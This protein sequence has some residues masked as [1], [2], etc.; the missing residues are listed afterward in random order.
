MAS[1]G[2]SFQKTFLGAAGTSASSTTLNVEDVFATSL[3]TGKGSGIYINNGIRLGARGGGSSVRFDGVDDRLSRAS[4]LTNAAD[5]KTFTLSAFVYPDRKAGNNFF[6]IA[7][8]G[9][10]GRFN[11][12]VDDTG[13]L[14]VNALG[15]DAGQVLTLESR[16][17]PSSGLPGGVVIGNWQHILISVD[18]SDTSK[19]HLYIDDVIPGHVDFDRYNDAVIDFT[20]PKV[21]IA[22]SPTAVAGAQRLSNFYLDFTYRDLSTES[23]RRLF[24]NANLEPVAPP[25]NS[26]IHMKLDGTDANT[27]VNSGTGGNFTVNGSPTVL[28]T[29]G[30]FQNSD[31]AAGGLVW[32][33]NRTASASNILVD[34]ERGAKKFLASDSTAA[35][36][37]GNASTSN[38]SVMDFTA[39]G[40]RI[41]NYSNVNV[42][43]AAFC[44]WTF[45]KQAK[46]FDVVTYSGQ[47][48]D[49]A[50]SHNLGVA[51][52]MVII[53]RTDDS[54]H[55]WYVYHRSLNLSDN[56]VLNADGD[57][58]GNNFW[59]SSAP[60][61]T[62][63]NI[64]GN[65]A[66]IN[67]SGGS[68]VAY[69][70]AH[71]A[72]DAT[73]TDFGSD[74]GPVI[75]CGS[76]TGNTSGT[77]VDLGFEPQFVMI[78]KSTASESWYVYDNMRGVATGGANS[79]DKKLRWNTSG[80]EAAVA[81]PIIAFSS[82]GFI[83]ESTDNEINGSGTYVYMAIR[84]LMGAPTK[85]LTGVPISPFSAVT[86]GTPDD[87]VITAF[88]F[89][90]EY[91]DMVMFAKRGGDSENFQIADRV[92]GFQSTSTN[93]DDGYT[94]STLETN[95]TNA[96]DTSSTA[97]HQTTTQ[98]DYPIGP[99]LRSVSSGGNFL[100]YR[101]RRMKGY[102]DMVTWTGT[103]S[104]RTQ[105]H[106]LGAVPEMIWV[107]PRNLAENWAVY[108]KDIGATKYLQLNT[109]AAA[110]TS[111]TR[112]NDTTPT[113][114]VF[115]LGAD[116]EVNASS[117]GPYTY[118]A[119]LFSTLDGVSKV[120]SYTGNDG[121]T[122]VDCGFSNGARFILIK[123]TNGS[124]DWFIFD[125]TRG[126][127][128]GN[129]PSLKLNTTEAED[130]LGARDIIDPLSAGFTVNAN[131]GGVNDNG[132]TFI[133]YAIA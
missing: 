67:Q 81:S 94:T 108:H 2:S 40:F 45:R 82:K 110:A 51:P 133:F 127:V 4:E 32:V 21:G 6:E 107:H 16:L 57:T 11:F 76:Y 36:V 98:V 38:Q 66:A 42:N 52:G 120:G 130:D 50:L 14:N 87:N 34:T 114:S 78:K 58:G 91:T 26:I 1:H 44:S 70:F 93:S 9:G 65:R 33:K 102:F 47:N 84:R 54:G 126:I 106:N 3:Y 24:V 75:S 86:T 49:L 10:S 59:T 124:G 69:L 20:N 95:N 117:G 89:R 23:N 41:G 61:S 31:G 22:G 62:V 80:A 113:S 85:D 7:N 125:S 92:R 83:L 90:P 53:K 8:S 29:L 105:V 122:N 19:R 132:D 88:P 77:E 101:W 118:I 68:Y 56:L 99:L 25:A 71:H 46:F 128:A 123:K 111:S 96:E 39:S 27:G 74:G 112:W 60:S 12:N 37:S 30:P 104:A 63:F 17:V 115:S 109:T 79:L 5:S 48:T 43:A 73:D 15:T 129:D 119:Y 18:M 116:N 131:R 100:M 35:E 13:K 28:D 121:S 103:G 55:D 97:I 72:N 64:D